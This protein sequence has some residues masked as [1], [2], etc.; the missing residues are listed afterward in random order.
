MRDSFLDQRRVFMY[1]LFYLQSQRFHSFL[2]L[3][4]SAPKFSQIYGVTFLQ[5]HYCMEKF[6]YSEKTSSASPDQ[7]FLSPD[8]SVLSLLQSCLFQNV[9]QSESW[10]I[11]DFKMQKYSFKIPPCIFMVDSSF[12]FI[13][14][15]YF[16]VCVYQSAY[17]FTY[18][19]ASLLFPVSDYCE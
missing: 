17:P 14:E 8:P 2:Q 3:L 4:R 1:S 15:Y 18:L 7:R 5:L 6:N 16:T 19:K 11:Q 13:S 10:S 9:L 12:I